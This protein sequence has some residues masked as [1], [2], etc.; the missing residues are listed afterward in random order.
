MEDDFLRR[1]LNR[2]PSHAFSQHAHQTFQ[3]HQAFRTLSETATNSCGARIISN[4]P[5][6]ARKIKK[7]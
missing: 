5:I 3:K 4:E 6:L 7:I 2:Q 1:S